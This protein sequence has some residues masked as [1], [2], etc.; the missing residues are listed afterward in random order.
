MN[1][2][3]KLPMVNLIAM[4]CVAA[5]G[6]FGMQRVSSSLDD[7]RSVVDV[8]VANEMQ[9][10]DM[11]LEFKTQ[12][13]E[14]KNVLLRGKD[15]KLRQAHWASFEKT[16]GH[17]AETAAQ[18][19]Q[20]LHP[21]QSRDLVQA[22]AKAHEELGRQYRRG[23]QAF[24]QGDF[25]PTLGDRAVKGID[26]APSDLISQA[27]TSISTHTRQVAD[28]TAANAKKMQRLSLFLALAVGVVATAVVMWLSRSITRAIDDARHVAE[29]VASG[30]LRQHIHSN[31]GDELGALTRALGTMNESLA[32][33]VSTVRTSA[34]SI[35]TGSGQIASGSADLS[36][37][38]EEQ[39]ASLEQTT[40]SI[41][42][43]DETV[44]HTT[45][46]A[47]KAATIACAAATAATRGGDVVGKVIATMDEISTSSRRISEIIGVI[48][49][50][51]FQTN[52]LAL[53]AAVEAA[54]AGEHGRGFA[55]VAAEVRS[56]AQRCTMAAKEIK[57]LISDSV[58]RVGTGTQLV[59]QA[60]REM[61]DLVS[62][63]HSVHALIKEIS[64]DSR[65]ESNGF[66]QISTAMG[67]LDQVTQHNAALVEENAAAAESLKQQ[68]DRLVKVVDVFK[69]VTP[70]TLQ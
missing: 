47:Q 5:A 46:T 44:K 56:L 15:P 2:A 59:G 10:S 23:Y 38:T 19:L 12:I 28:A 60:G 17:V 41:Q 6:V 54:R 31:G 26:R 29:T 37:R 45:E 33:L 20:K 9:V 43:I 22:F 51:A 1:L 65:D 8:D 21:G 70:G 4:L 62:Q 58:N 48:D 32:G 36:Q 52:I 55:V 13:Q 67:H 49:G 3:T 16:E 30:D 66:E 35:A 69:L 61:A 7:V 24:Q 25:D 63:V 50:I 14:W 27:R 18:L 57:G 39:A 11:Q 34:E 53:N 42:A 68:A 40:A 64:S